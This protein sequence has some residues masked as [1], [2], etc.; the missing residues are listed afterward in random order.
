MSSSLVGIIYPNTQHLSDFLSPMLKLLK[1]RPNQKQERHQFKNFQLGISGESLAFNE[2]KTLCLALD[3]FIEDCLE[4]R[5]ELKKA[6][7]RMD[8]S[9]QGLL[10]AAY[11]EWGISFLE[12]I[13]GD[14]AFALFDQSKETL[15]LARD[16][17][18][19]KPLYWYEG[20][21]YFI[22]S[23]EIKTLLAS[24][25]IPQTPAQDAYATYLYFG[26]FP[27]DITPI[28]NVNKLLPGHYIQFK[29]NIGK[30]IQPY[31]SYSQLFKNRSYKSKDQILSELDA[32]LISSLKQRIPENGEIGCIISGGLGSAT[33][34][35]YLSEHLGKKPLNT[36]TVG[37]Q[38]QNEDDISCAKEI[39][40]KL[41]CIPHIDLIDPSHIFDSLVQIVWHLDEPIGDPGI[42][43]TW[44]LSKM[45]KEV[46]SNVFSGMGSDE[47]FAGHS[48]YTTAERKTVFMDPIRE[49]L[50]KM[51]LKSLVSLSTIL[52]SHVLFSTLKKLKKNPWQ[53]E[54]LLHNAL[55]EEDE[56]AKISPNLAQFFDTDIFLHKF[57]HLE[58]IPS[59]VASFLYFDVKTRLP[60]CFIAQYERLTKAHGLIWQTPFL[61]HNLVEF[62]AGLLNLDTLKEEE[63]ASLLKPL[64]KDIFPSSVIDRPKKTRK[65][66]LKS[67]IELESVFSTFSLLKKGMLVQTGMISPK[68][69]EKQLKIPQKNPKI[70]R[71]LWAVLVLEIWT[72]LYI[73]RFPFSSPPQMSVQE[74]LQS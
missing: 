58:D 15:F 7:H 34:A 53:F 24:G 59:K 3:G 47:L 45:A 42:A 33:I 32:L 20:K 23:S 38:G 16:R 1:Y 72:R 54:F 69:I 18:G 29:L 55:F 12:K 67:W 68:W 25:V 60:D 14:F 28:Q 44:Q 43:V 71:Q 50:K 46:A 6:G 36:F 37:F 57:H 52:H 66:F 8:E 19:K 26:Y 27:Q 31:W 61:S 5:Q 63:T 10:L 49:S 35:Y 48:R 13:H 9:V 62:A 22:F 30:T 64:I 11:E 21:N 56:L 41:N 2:N 4:L 17:I 65:A 70:F 73:N 39:I 51:V 74:F 40:S